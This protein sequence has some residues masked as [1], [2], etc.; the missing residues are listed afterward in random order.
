M[1]RGEMRCHFITLHFITLHRITSHY[2]TLDHI[3]LHGNILH[4]LDEGSDF[5]SLI[6]LSSLT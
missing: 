5:A 3:T 6:P 2:I 4:R 1:R